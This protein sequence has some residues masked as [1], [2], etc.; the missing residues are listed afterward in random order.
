MLS[1]ASD[2]EAASAAAY[3]EQQAQSIGIPLTDRAVTGDVIDYSVFSSGQFDAAILGW[4]VSRY[5][6]YLC[7]WFGSGGPFQYDPG[8]VLSLCGELQATSDLAG[9]RSKLGAIQNALAQDVPMVP[10][11]AEMVHDEYLH[12]SYPFDSVLDG[13]AGNFGAPG[14]VMPGA[15]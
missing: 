15:P 10:L 3:V 11:Y 5:P 8:R 9:A 4:T 1:N 14:L 13:L 12:V 7:D 6:G 2:T